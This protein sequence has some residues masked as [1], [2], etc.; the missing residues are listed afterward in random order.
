[1]KKYIREM[2]IPYYDG[3]KTGLVQPY[4]LLTYMAEVSSLH[5]DSLDLGLKNLRKNN[6]GWML[7]R[8]KVKILKYPKVLDKIYVETWPSSFYKFYA[9]REFVIYDEDKNPICLASTIWVFLDI[10]K[11]RLLRIPQEFY[12]TYGIIEEKLNED[13]YDFKK[14]F[15]TRGNLDFRV[16]RSDIDYNNHV[17]NTKYLNWMIEAM[18]ENIYDGYRVSE[19]DIQY[20]RE[21]KLGNMVESSY[22]KTDEA[23]P[24]F[25]HKIATDNEINAYGRTVWK[26]Y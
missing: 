5:S 2:T 26:K 22:Q 19:L 14:D 7:N 8:W 25:L 17:N 24:T 23:Q 11:K 10:T 18:P 12:D 3:D 9:N 4:M 16:R 1:M 6:Y 13:F 20:K 21:I 15:T